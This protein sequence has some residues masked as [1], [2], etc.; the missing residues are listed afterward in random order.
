MP[1]HA[2]PEPPLH[3]NLFLPGGTRQFQSKKPAKLNTTTLSQLEAHSETHTGRVRDH[4]EDFYFEDPE[5]GLWIVADGMGGHAAGEVASRIATESIRQSLADGEELPAAV[6]SAHG[7]VVEAMVD[8]PERA[9]MG[10][11]VVAAQFDR[12]GYTVAWV[13][14]SRAYRLSQQRFELLSRDH[15]LYE[16]MILEGRAGA[17]EAAQHPDA[18]TLVQAIGVAGNQ[19]PQA[20]WITGALD[21]GECLLLCTDGL[22]DELNDGEIEHILRT[23]NTPENM[24]KA[25]VQAA[26]ESGGR[27]NITLALIRNAAAGSSPVGESPSAAD[28]NASSGGSM[29][30]KIFTGVLILALVAVIGWILLR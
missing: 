2:S 3:V 24:G 29:K 23:E 27:D 20:E 13:G 6:E 1:F 25:L 22:T 14:D 28:H 16:Q 5:Q 10:T 4:N 7:D 18:G 15:N 11:T 30:Y 21:S 17:E 12:Q 8:H 19:Q 9:G 26:L